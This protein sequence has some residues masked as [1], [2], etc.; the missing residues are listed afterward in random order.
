MFLKD[1]HLSMEHCNSDYYA[2]D[3]AVHTHGKM[4]ACIQTEI[5]AKLQHDGNNTNIGVNKVKWKFIMITIHTTT[6]N[7]K[8]KL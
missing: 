7:K 5:E 3:A 6:Q 1:S 2:D 8:L 4:R